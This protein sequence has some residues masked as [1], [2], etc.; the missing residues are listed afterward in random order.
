MTSINWDYSEIFSAHFGGPG[1][2]TTPAQDDPGVRGR[3]R[4]SGRGSRAPDIPSPARHPGGLPAG[5][6]AGPTGR[7][8]VITSVHC[9]F[10][11]GAAAG[12]GSSRSAAGGPA[13]AEGRGLAVR[14]GPTPAAYAHLSA[15]PAQCVLGAPGL[16][17]P[18]GTRPVRRRG[19][20]CECVCAGEKMAAAGEAA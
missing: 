11:S 4:T 16:P 15:A 19:G 3:G 7:F 8:G 17:A 20:R 5:K 2:R 9:P 1:P 14:P 12:P 10:P 6:K 13:S 18:R